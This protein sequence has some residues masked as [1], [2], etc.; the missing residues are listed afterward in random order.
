MKAH[1][2]RQG[3]GVLAFAVDNHHVEAIK[4]RYEQ[5]HPTLIDSFY[6]EELP[7]GNKQHKILEVFA[8]YH[9]HNGGGGETSNSA[10]LADPGTVL[11]F[12]QSDNSGSSESSSLLL[13]DDAYSTNTTTAAPSCCVLLGL[14]P[15]DA[16]FEDSSMAAYCD[17]WVSN[18]FDRTEFLDTLRDTLGFTPKVDFN[19]G[20]VAAGEAQIESTV[21]GNTS[22]RV[23]ES[24]EAALRDQSQVYLPINN[25][26]SPVGHVHGFLQELGQ[27]VQHVASRVENLVDFVQRGNEYREITGEGPLHMFGVCACTVLLFR[28]L[29]SFLR[30]LRVNR[31]L[32]PSNPEI[33]LWNTNV[34]TT[35]R[36]DCR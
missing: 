6:D 30:L 12:V 10:R 11:R 27:G 7:T 25:A 17:H 2:G 20:V 31:F 36:R 15:C 32:L 13:T 19:A 28:R 8:C 33:I 35:R 21:T 22:T 26:L 34:S 14:S 16:V 3:V 4:E 1:R 5:L 9:E 24:K 18:V 23:T 29:N